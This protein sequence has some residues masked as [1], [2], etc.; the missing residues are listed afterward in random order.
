MHRDGLRKRLDQD[1]IVIDIRMKSNVAKCS[2][3]FLDND[4]VN[5]NLSLDRG[6]V[7]NRD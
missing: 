4:L 7:I 6:N 3:V 5:R 2:N 1:A